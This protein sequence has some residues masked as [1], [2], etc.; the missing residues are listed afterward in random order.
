MGSKKGEWRRRATREGWWWQDAV[1]LKEGGWG[2]RRARRGSQL[3]GTTGRIATS[4]DSPGQDQ[5]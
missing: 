5:G 1:R 2:S 4:P 3:D